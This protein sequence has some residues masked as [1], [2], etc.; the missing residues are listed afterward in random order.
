M[1]WRAFLDKA[2]RLNRPLGTLDKHI[3]TRY[4]VV[5]LK[6][7]DGALTR[8]LLSKRTQYVSCCYKVPKVEG[9]EFAAYGRP[10]GFL[11]FLPT[12]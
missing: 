4:I 7:C 5:A 1:L 8:L 11:Q 9:H 3:V 12:R 6:T 10:S 2:S